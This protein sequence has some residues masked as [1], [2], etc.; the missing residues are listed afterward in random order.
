[1]EGTESERKIEDIS[2][3]KVGRY[4][5]HEGEAFKVTSLAHSKSG[6]HGHAKTRLEAVSVVGNKKISILGEDKMEV[7]IIDKRSAQIL[8]LREDVEQRGMETIRKKIANVM[9]TETYETFDLEVPEEL[10]SI[11]EGS[12]VIY[13]LVMN[14]RV[15]Q[16]L[17]KKE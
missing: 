10:Y 6:K 13:W 15:M 9:D 3:I 7:P 8:T 17:K 2:K 5:V 12:E 1:M 4:I 14:Q 11:T 16:Q